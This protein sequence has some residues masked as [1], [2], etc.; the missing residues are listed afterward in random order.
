MFQPFLV[1][2]WG[3]FNKEKYIS[4][5]LYHRCAIIQIVQILKWLKYFRKPSAMLFKFDTLFC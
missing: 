2:L 1:H 3:V 4:V 5:Q